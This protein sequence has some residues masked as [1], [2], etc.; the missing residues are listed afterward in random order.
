MANMPD[1]LRKIQIEKYKDKLFLDVPADVRELDGIEA[2]RSIQKKKYDLVMAFVFSLEQ[3]EARVAEMSK[4]DL[5]NKSGYLYL[6]YPKKGNKRY[7]EYIHRDSIFTLPIDEDSGYY[8]DSNLKLS[9]M[10]SFNDVFTLGGFKQTP[11]GSKKK[12]PGVSQCVGDYEKMVPQLLQ[13]WEKDGEVKQKYAALTPGYQR[14]W[15]RYVYSAQSEE[16]LQKRLGEMN[17]VL[18]QGYKSISLYKRDKR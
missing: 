6:V 2:D 4:K 9:R 11:H 5:L 10:V 15:A 16:T 8:K 7:E 1:A 18:R 3:F 12:A 17:I 14:G 13:Y